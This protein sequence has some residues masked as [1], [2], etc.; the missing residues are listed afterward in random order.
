MK[1]YFGM[2]SSSVYLFKII[3]SQFYK[4]TK[5]YSRKTCSI[6]Q[7]ICSELLTMLLVTGN[8]V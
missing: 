2:F 1:K 6:K 4:F 8:V 7:L 5:I 3:N